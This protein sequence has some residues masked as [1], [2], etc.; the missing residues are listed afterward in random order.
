VWLAILCGH[1][2]RFAL[3]RLRFEQGQWR[4]IAVE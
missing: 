3:S 4:N 1:F 2:T